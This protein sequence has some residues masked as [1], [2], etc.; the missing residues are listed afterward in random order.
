MIK[1]LP[2]QT[3]K[4]LELGKATLKIIITIAY[5]FEVAMTIRDILMESF[6]STTVKAF[7]LVAL[8]LIWIFLYV[9]MMYWINRLY[10]L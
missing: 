7:I 8:S 4:E 10:D 2:L 1:L 6:C 5:F 9:A 3:V